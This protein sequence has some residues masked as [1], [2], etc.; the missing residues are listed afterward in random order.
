MGRTTRGDKGRDKIRRL[1]NN[2]CIDGSADVAPC[3]STLRVARRPRPARA[4]WLGTIV[5]NEQKNAREY[6]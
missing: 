1:F 2:A 6:D 5:A 3:E 4:G